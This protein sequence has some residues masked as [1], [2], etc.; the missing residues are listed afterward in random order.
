[1]FSKGWKNRTA[2]LIAVD[3]DVNRTIKVLKRVN[4]T[5]KLCE[6]NIMRQ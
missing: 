5:L 2:N 4:E 1:M 6:R 3:E